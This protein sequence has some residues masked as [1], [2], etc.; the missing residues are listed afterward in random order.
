[1]TGQEQ[2]HYRK[3]RNVVRDRHKIDWR[4]WSLASYGSLIG[5][6]ALGFGV[7]LFFV[8]LVGYYLGIDMIMN[9]AFVGSAWGF[10]MFFGASLASMAAMAY[11]NLSGRWNEEDVELVETSKDCPS[12][13]ASL[14]REGETNVYRCDE[15]RFE[16]M[17]TLTYRLRRWI[18]ERVR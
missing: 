10:L 16:G 18:G 4:S 5:E 15:C 6:T 1:M 12:C 9:L 11:N 17:E 7:V 14:L 2:D 13:G 3:L 8:S